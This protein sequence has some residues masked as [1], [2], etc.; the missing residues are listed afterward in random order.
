MKLKLKLDI[1]A[2][3]FLKFL[4]NFKVIFLNVKF[5]I[6]FC[7]NKLRN[8]LNFKILPLYFNTKND[9]Y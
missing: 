2:C 9:P 3:N 4:F 6:Q 8:L 5:I 7:L 1:F